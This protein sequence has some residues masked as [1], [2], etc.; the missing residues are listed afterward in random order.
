VPTQWKNEED[1]S[2]GIRKL[3]YRMDALGAPSLKSDIEANGVSVS[4]QESAFRNTIR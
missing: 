2:E 3:M 1:L 4:V